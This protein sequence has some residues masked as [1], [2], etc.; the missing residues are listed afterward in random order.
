MSGDPLDDGTTPRGYFNGGQKIYEAE[1]SL[2][3]ESNLPV[4]RSNN[5]GLYDLIGNVSEWCWDWYDP[6]WYSR[7]NKSQS[8]YGPSYHHDNAS[9]QSRLHREGGTKM[10]REWM[11]VSH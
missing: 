11:R 5:F 8:S 7:K 1:L 6:Q 9:G 2:D 10:D 3:G 4:D